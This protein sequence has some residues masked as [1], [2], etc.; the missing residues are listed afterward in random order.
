MNMNRLTVKSSTLCCF[1]FSALAGI[2]EAGAQADLF[3]S[4]FSLSPT[5]P[6]QGQ[7]VDVR[8]GVYNKGTAPAGRF[9]VEWWA[10][11]N[12]QSPACTWA[13]DDLAARGGRILHCRY[14]GYPS[15]YS[16]LVTKAVADPFGSVAE[17]EEANNV[18]TMTIQVAKAG[19]AGQPNLSIA[20]IALSPAPPT[21]G[22]PVQVKVKVHNSGTAAAGPFKVEWWPGERFP[23]PACKWRVN[24]L[25][26]GDTTLQ[27]CTYEGYRSWYSSLVTKAVADVS[28]DVA[29]SDERDNVTRMEIRVGKP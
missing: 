27:R 18:R 1:L 22:R 15:W 10:G 26:S 20:A 16:K 4:E 17:T 25:A 2:S 24:G 29:E 12:Y 3:I 11:E 13:V 19:A 14:A 5:V 21:Q 6:E 9:K 7:P 28:N 8:L 23:E